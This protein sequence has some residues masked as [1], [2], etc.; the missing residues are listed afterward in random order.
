M[1]G[2]HYNYNNIILFSVG[3]ENVKINV[4]WR[5]QENKYQLIIL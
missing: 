4:K 2:K 3:S 1:Y 5:K